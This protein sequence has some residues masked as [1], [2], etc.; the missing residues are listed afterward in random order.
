M[1][2]PCRECEER[3]ETCHAECEKYLAFR[4]ECEQRRKERD[5]NAN[6]R[7]YFGQRKVKTARIFKRRIYGTHQNNT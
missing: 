7:D 5:K 6:V 4:A 1:T 2:C 3:T